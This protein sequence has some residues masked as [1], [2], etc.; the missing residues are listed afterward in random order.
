MT[1]AYPRTLQQRGCWVL[2]LGLYL[3][4][5]GSFI[6]AA[7]VALRAD[8]P[9]TYTVVKGDTLWDIAGQFLAEPWMWPQVWQANPQID[10]PDLIYPG[11]VIELV[12]ENGSPVL[13]VSQP[14]AA[15]TSGLPTI[16]LSPQ[17]RR[18]N[19]SSP[20]PAISLEQ[21]SAFL[22]SNSFVDSQV[23][24]DAPYLL[25]ERDGSSIFATGH[26][27]FGRGQ[28][29][30]GIFSYDIV[31]YGRELKDPDTNELLGVEA[32][33]V[34]SATVKTTNGQEATLIID[35]SDRE[36]RPG[37]RFIPNLR[38][39]LDSSYLPS[40]PTFAVDAAIVTI[41]DGRALGG[42]YHT[43]I[44]N[45]GKKAGIDTGHIL[46][47]QEPELEVIDNQGPVSRLQK[48]QRFIGMDGGRTVAFPGENIAT[49]LIY[50]VFEDASYGLIIKNTKDVRM[51][52][53][54]VT[55]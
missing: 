13:R 16:K 36:A 1:I 20:I 27:I 28:W 31:H 47:V 39:P 23:L 43:L 30:P 41:D 19:I 12:F 38:V 15:E 46:V 7:E 53:K 21:I 50:S 6:S 3:V 8:T 26:E 52:D 11:D 29:T 32:V 2:I 55:P 24:K 40:P 34:G 18:S 44:L 35:A 4:L 25:A 54:V 49:V 10:N 45:K 22:S 37:D 14:I 17:V 9:Q 5:G 48:L 51:G 42:L 33:Y